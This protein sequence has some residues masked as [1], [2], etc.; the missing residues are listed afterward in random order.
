MSQ[1]DGDPH[2][3]IAPPPIL[4]VRHAQDAHRNGDD[5]GLTLG[6]QAQ[7]QALAAWLVEHPERYGV[8]YVS[9]RRRAR[10]T[11]DILARALRLRAAVDGLTSGLVALLVHGAFEVSHA[12]VWSR[13]Q[14]H[15]YL[16]SPLPYLLLGALS[17][18]A[19]RFG[20]S[21]YPPPPPCRPSARSP[22][23]HAPRDLLRPA[24]PGGRISVARG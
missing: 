16:A 21:P 10:E 17:G 3:R 5:P 14:G 1:P 6:G 18:L 20:F 11:A 23:A 9:P 2:P 22:F 19:D 12:I 13:G 24:L 4:L 7:A 8:V 15:G